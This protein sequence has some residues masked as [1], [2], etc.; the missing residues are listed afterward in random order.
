[1]GIA[2]C[3]LSQYVIRPTLVYLD[4]YSPAAEMM[5]LATAATQSALGA[6]LENQ[7]HHGIYRITAERHA[8]LW[9][10]YL[11]HDPERAS[12]VRGLASQ[13]AFF[14]APHLELTV[15]LRYATA[16]AWLLIE[17]SGLP[18]P[19]PADRQGQARLWRRVFNSQGR[20]QDFLTAWRHCS[21]AW[22]QVA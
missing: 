9:D 17:E 3:E 10:A 2:A 7:E 21:E 16:I 5:L 1:M 22:N 19:S 20:L 11:A 14:G 15:N 13:H 18:L 4:R 6:T 12:L 8:A